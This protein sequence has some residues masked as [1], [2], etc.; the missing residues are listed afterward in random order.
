MRAGHF[1]SRPPQRSRMLA[2]P[3]LGR[4]SPCPQTYK[5]TYFQARGIVEHCRLLF[6]IANVP[7]EDFRYPIDPAT[8][9]RPEFGASP[10]PRLFVPK[11]D[12]MKRTQRSKYRDRIGIYLFAVAVSGLTRSRARQLTFVPRVASFCTRSRNPHPGSFDSSHPSIRFFSCRAV[13]SYRV[14]RPTTPP[15][16][17]SR[18]Q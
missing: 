3:D 7:F 14:I 15:D 10:T 17:T 5:L 9:A 13:S 18:Q 1:C 12:S 8:Y 11:N 4:P 2:T 6:K 16:S